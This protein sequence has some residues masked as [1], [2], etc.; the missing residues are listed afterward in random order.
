MGLTTIAHELCLTLQEEQPDIVIL[1]ETKLVRQQH[2]RGWVKAMFADVAGQN[3]Y[4][5]YC[6]SQ[7]ATF[8]KSRR[9]TARTGSGGVLIAVHNRWQPSTTVNVMPH[10]KHPYL[11]GHA[12]GVSIQTPHGRPLDVY[13]VYMPFDL[14]HRGQIYAFLEA[15][16]RSAYTIWAGD[17][18]AD[19]HRAQ[20]MGSMVRAADRQHAH[21]VEGFTDLHVHSSPDHQPTHLPVASSCRASHLDHF[22][23]SSN[24]HAMRP[25]VENLP[26]TEDSEHVQTIMKVA[27]MSR[28][29]VLPPSHTALPRKRRLKLPAKQDQLLRFKE[30]VA[31]EFA[32]QI[33]D[34]K[35][36]LQH[37]LRD[38]RLRTEAQMHQLAESAHQ[39]TSSDILDLAFARLDHVPA[40]RQQVSRHLPRKQARVLNRAIS[41]AQALKKCREDYK[42]AVNNSRDETHLMEMLD[43]ARSFYLGRLDARGRSELPQPPAGMPMHEALQSWSCWYTASAEKLAELQALRKHLQKLVETENGNRARKAFQKLLATKQKKANQLISGKQGQHG[44]TALRSTTGELI[45]S[46]AGLLELTHAYFQQQAAAPTQAQTL[47]TPPWENQDLDG[48]ELVA[49]AKRPGAKQVDFAAMMSD[50]ARF[51]QHVKHLANGKAPGPDEVPNEVLKYLPEDMLYCLHAMIQ[52]IFKTSSTPTC[53]KSS[54]TVLL[55]KDKGDPT[56]LKNYRPICLSNT[57]S[58]L[59]TGMLADCMTDYSD[60]FDILTAGQEGFRRNKSTARQLQVVVNALTDAKMT[61]Q[62]IFA[63]FVDFSSAFNTIYH[64][65]LLWIMDH[66]GFPKCCTAAVASLYQDSYTKINIAG[67]STPPVTIESGTLQGDSLSPFLFINAIDPLLRWLYSGGRGYALGATQGTLKVPVASYADD[68]LALTRC[69][70]DLAVQALKIQLYSDWAGLHPNVSKCAMTGAMYGYARACKY[71]NPFAEKYL[72]MTEDRLQGVTLAGGTPRFLH[73]QKDAYRYLGVDMTLDLN[74]TQHVSRTLQT[75]KEKGAA[76]LLSMASARQTHQYIQTSIRP[77]ITYAFSTGAFTYED[78]TRLDAAL[79]RIMRAAYRVPMSTPNALICCKTEDGGMGLQSLLVDYAQITAASLTMALNDAGPLGQSTRAL[80]SLQHRLTAGQQVLHLKGD[81]LDRKLARSTRHLHLLRQLCLLKDCNIKIDCPSNQDLSVAE[82]HVIECLDAMQD[83]P[84]LQGSMRA[85]LVKYMPVLYECGIATLD[86]V[87]HRRGDQILMRPASSIKSFDGLQCSRR[88]IIAYNRLTLL[89]SSGVESKSQRTQDLTEAQRTITDENMLLQYS[90][91]P[92]LKEARH[93]TPRSATPLSG[94]TAGATPRKASMLLEHVFAAERKKAQARKA[95]KRS[96]T[97]T[98]PE[99]AKCRKTTSA[100]M[101]LRRSK[102]LAEQHNLDQRPLAEA[103][104][105]QSSTPSRLALTMKHIGSCL[106]W[107]CRSWRTTSGTTS[108]PTQ[109][110]CNTP[111]LHRWKPCWL[112]T[113]VT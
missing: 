70:T 92:P 23:I 46:Q 98:L 56:E 104:R 50:R 29:M 38:P 107:L 101:P 102:R 48:F 75:V 2:C 94:I 83:L 13:G 57:I 106:L 42:A 25:F 72:L 52:L 93:S 31:S 91:E 14:A 11:V 108:R 54:N 95:S 76:I 61:Q 88:H 41:C 45:T 17:W 51:D 8:D 71:E 77:C 65:K 3:Q 35:S 84:D 40:D 86:Q 33:H 67:A 103:E 78:I 43:R 27:D 109:T 5:L 68:L 82:N 44:I 21:F 34:L 64:D 90:L 60:H 30:E 7:N 4:T 97:A 47:C 53:M 73:P 113:I 110:G 37:T 89:L 105:T 15:S 69:P 55:Y 22:L 18:N 66:L 16:T 81:K 85:A 36:S 12:L 79:C 39:L 80:L 58:K 1:T 62:D 59:Y 19:L 9:S 99:P 63:L 26:T 32:Q 112:D 100:N 111:P 87:L 6:S 28:V 49:E 24:L 10:E 20:E 74:W 96:S